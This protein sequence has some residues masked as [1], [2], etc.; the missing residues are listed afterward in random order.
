MVDGILV[1]IDNN[2]QMLPLEL[3]DKH[4]MVSNRNQ[5]GRRYWNEKWRDWSYEVL[6]VEPGVD[7]TGF[8]DENGG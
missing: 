5:I 6:N 2:G 3:L 8:I 4:R 1:I 7:V